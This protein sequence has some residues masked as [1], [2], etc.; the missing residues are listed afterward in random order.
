[1]A[2]TP[3]FTHDC[4]SCLFLGRYE[5]TATLHGRDYDLYYCGRCD[6]GSV[7]ARFGSDGWEYQ[8]MPVAVIIGAQLDRE[9]PLLEALRRQIK[10]WI[11][12][13]L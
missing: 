10:V 1:M 2:D 5:D 13:S 6:E 12:A 9:H 4:N 7:I 8:S 3:Q 11:E